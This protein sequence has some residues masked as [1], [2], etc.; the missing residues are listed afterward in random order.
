MRLLSVSLLKLVRRP[1]SRRTI[2]VMAGFLALIYVSVGSATKALPEGDQR[3]AMEQILA[4][5]DAYRSLASML[6]TF[7]GLAAAAYA[8]TIAGSEWSWGAFRVA[9]SRGESRIGYVLGT[10]VALAIVVAIAWLVL[11]ALGIVLVLIAG[12]VGGVAAGDATG[13]VTTLLWL[14]AAGWWAIAMQA[15]IGFAASFVTRSQVAGIAAIVALTLGEQFAAMFLPS[16]V[17]RLA[18]LGAGS[19]LLVRVTDGAVLEAV[20]AAGMIGLYLLVAV[21]LA[22]L[23]A[24]RT[25]VA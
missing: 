8:G 5:P 15:G 17:L 14:L 25:E 16:E 9:I 20:A 18:P 12:V 22:G 6:V 19:S 7:V 23:L 21:G 11:F 3:A 2:A 4:F 13:S 24:R 1:A 10:F